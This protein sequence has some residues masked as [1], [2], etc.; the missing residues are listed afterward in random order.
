VLWA[1]TAYVTSTSNRPN[2]PTTVFAAQRQRN[3]LKRCVLLGQYP[4]SMTFTAATSIR[5]QRD[6][7]S[8]HTQRLNAY[9]TRTNWQFC[10]VH[11][12]P[13]HSL[14]TRLKL[15]KLGNSAFPDLAYT[16]RTQRN[17]L[18]TFLRTQATQQPKRKQKSSAH[19]RVPWT[20]TRFKPG[21]KINFKK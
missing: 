2:P 19:I 9:T 10:L 18:R 13:V 12:S 20:K 4:M 14:C 11:F 6:N 1:L 8:A 7:N 3:L 21:W 16:Q 17:A 5:W 15:S